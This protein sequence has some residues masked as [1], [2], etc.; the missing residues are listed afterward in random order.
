MGWLPK[1]YHWPQVSIS[2]CGLE[3]ADFSEIGEKHRVGKGQ[4][5]ITP[6]S[7]FVFEMCLYG[8]MNTCIFH[9][10]VTWLYMFYEQMLDNDTVNFRMTFIY[11]H[12]S[13]LKQKTVHYIF[14][15]NLT[16]S[17]SR[18]GK[19]HHLQVPNDRPGMKSKPW[20]CEKQ[21]IITFMIIYNYIYTRL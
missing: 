7:G 10:W 18:G 19:K 5:K 15:G 21:A 6:L 13:N 17:A 2:P 12:F 3:G 4:W 1:P 9:K 11:W 14:V 8:L 16:K 20:D